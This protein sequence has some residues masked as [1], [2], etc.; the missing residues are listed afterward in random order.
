MM[1]LTAVKQ[2]QAF[3]PGWLTIKGGAY[4]TGV[5]FQIATRTEFDQI[6]HEA[7]FEKGASDLSFKM[8]GEDEHV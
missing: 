4:T 6:V 8:M 7:V 2:A 1:N 3:C 5:T